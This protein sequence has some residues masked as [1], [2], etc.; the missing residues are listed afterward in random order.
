LSLSAAGFAAGA[1]VWAKARPAVA[2]ATSNHERERI[3]ANSWRA[4][5]ARLE[6]FKQSF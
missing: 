3:K 4:A 2:S 5:P 6:K 1:G